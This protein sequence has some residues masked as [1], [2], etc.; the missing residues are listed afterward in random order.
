LKTPASGEYSGFNPRFCVQHPAPSAV[1]A[2]RSSKVNVV[3]LWMPMHPLLA[4]SPMFKYARDALA[5]ELPAGRYEWLDIED[6]K[7]FV[8]VDLIHLT[9]PSALRV[10]EILR[11]RAAGHE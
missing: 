4:A 3:L 2:L 6:G 9:G 11:R 5:R 10:A 1:D 8:T 7:P